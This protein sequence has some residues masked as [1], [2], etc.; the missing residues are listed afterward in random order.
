MRK[1]I[2]NLC[3]GD[4]STSTLN[5]QHPTTLEDM[6]L[7]LELEED[8][9]RKSNSDI[10]QSALNQY[11]RFSLDGKDAMYR[12]SFRNL[13]AR[14]SVCCDRGVLARE[15]IMNRSFHP[16]TTTSRGESVVWCKP[17]VIA[18]LMGLD[19]MP[20]PMP[21]THN[22]KETM[23]QNLRRRLERHEIENRDQRTMMKMR[24]HT[25]EAGWPTR[26]FYPQL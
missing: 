18:K 19:A 12:S 8:K 11:P 7:Q 26:R 17:G 20:M 16:N 21:I 24:M 15:R 25:K 10:L 22:R 5:Q 1:G 23:R 9:A 14:K 4:G 2:R 3:N 6:I 13:P